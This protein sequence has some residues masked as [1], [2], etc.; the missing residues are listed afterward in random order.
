MDDATIK[1][2]VRKAGE[3]GKFFVVKFIKQDKTERTL[4][5]R[6]GVTKGLAGGKATTGPEYIRIWDAK[7]KQYRNVNPSTVFYIKGNGV[8][9]T[10]KLE[11]GS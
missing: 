8:S 2:L 5:G 4:N 10:R 1:T 3:N 7:V 11:K 6:L 9:F